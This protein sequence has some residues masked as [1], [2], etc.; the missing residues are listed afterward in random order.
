MPAHDL[1]PGSAYGMSERHNF[2]NA[3]STEGGQEGMTQF[4]LREAF[5]GKH[6]YRGYE[7]K[8]PCMPCLIGWESQHHALT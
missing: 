8:K 1:A 7:V 5:L 4:C 6:I 3:S 2:G